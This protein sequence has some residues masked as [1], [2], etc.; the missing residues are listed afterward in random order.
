MSASRLNWNAILKDALARELSTTEVAI[1]QGVAVPTV[2][3]AAA[4]RQVKLKDKRGLHGNRGGRSYHAPCSTKFVCPEVWSLTQQEAQFVAVLVDAD[5]M[6][7]H[8]Q[9]LAAITRQRFES[10]YAGYKLIDVIL[11]RARQKLAPFN[12]RIERVHGKG[13]LIHA[14]TVGQLR[15]GAVNVSF[16]HNTPPLERAA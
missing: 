8:K 14:E 5:G 2:C 16:K 12:I 4:R 3:K 10:R 1:E 9:M 11:C 6:V 7:T 13:M 15:A